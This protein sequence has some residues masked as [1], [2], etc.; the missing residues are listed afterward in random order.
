MP[1]IM[2]GNVVRTNKK[3]KS[4]YNKS[5]LTNIVA[6]NV[7]RTNTAFKDVRKIL[8]LQKLLKQT[9]LE[10]KLLEQTS[11]EQE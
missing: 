5:F 6:A 8:Q 1:V 7:V 3:N 4:R 9:S 10:Q 11:S 2:K